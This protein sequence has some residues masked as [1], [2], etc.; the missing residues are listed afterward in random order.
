MAGGKERIIDAAERLFAENG[1]HGVSM[2]MVADSASI[3]LGTLTHHFASKEALLETVVLR[4]SATLNRAQFDAIASVSDPGLAP[5]LL[6]FVESY[7]RLIESDDQGWRSYTRLIAIFATDARWSMLMSRQ[8]EEL[9]RAM[10]ARLREEEPGLDQ[11]TAVHA[12][13][14]L[15]SVVMGLFAS[16]GVLEQFSD[17]RLSGEHIRSNVDALICFAVGGIQALGAMSRCSGSGQI[18]AQLVI[19]KSQELL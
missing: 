19:E 15:V 2:R 17:G 1:F 18:R 4:R 6:A 16:N 14:S 9:G 11:D 5:L 8:F 13:A 12:Y 7:L 10:I 3:G